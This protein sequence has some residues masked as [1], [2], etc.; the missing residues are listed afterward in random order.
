MRYAAS[1]ASWAAEAADSIAASSVTPAAI[2]EARVY[3]KAESF[4]GSLVQ[5]ARA[6]FML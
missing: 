6:Y 2:V 5:A 3:S 4:A 1:A